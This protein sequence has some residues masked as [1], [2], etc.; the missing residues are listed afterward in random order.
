MGCQ[1]KEVNNHSS[2]NMNLIL[3]LSLILVLLYVIIRHDPI[4]GVTENGVVAYCNSSKY[5]L[6]DHYL[7]GLPTG[8]KWQCVEFVRRYYMQIHG[9]T[10]PSVANAYEM[11][12]LTEFIDINT[13]QSYPCTFYSP[14]ESTPQ[15][16]DILILE[17]EKYGHTAI[18]VGVQGK[19]I[20]IAEQNW[21]PWVASYYS[22]ELSVDDPLIIGWLVPSVGRSSSQT[23]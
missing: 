11:M 8:K 1:Q 21:D 5:N 2:S 4:C 6:V 19:R 16:D 12:K 17:Y 14:T 23:S 20:R 3:L 7:D 10:F 15:K 22:R 13:Q 18:I 9:L